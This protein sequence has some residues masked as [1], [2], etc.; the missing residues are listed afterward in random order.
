M[1]KLN[2][3]KPNFLFSCSMSL[4]WGAERAGHGRP[5]AEPTGRMDAPPEEPRPPK[6]NCL[7]PRARAG[8][9]ESKPRST[10]CCSN[11][12]VQYQLLKVGQ[13]RRQ[14]PPRYA[15]FAL[16]SLLPARVGRTHGLLL[17]SRLAGTALR[18]IISSNLFIDE[19]AVCTLEF[20]ITRPRRKRT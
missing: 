15:V 12:A 4:I 9:L 1:L 19:G 7:F 20:L 18:S 8:T 11:W 16:V 6:F 2:S 17:W 14:E 13:R 5:H 10:R 3:T